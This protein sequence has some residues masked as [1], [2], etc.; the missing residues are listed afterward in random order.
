M[1]R[2][3]EHRKL[4]SDLRE[5]LLHGP[6]WLLVE[7]HYTEARLRAVWAEYG[8]QVMNEYRTE[9][10]CGEPGF[11]P[12]AFW[13]FSAGREE[14]TA[15]CPEADGNDAEFGRAL[16]EYEFEP[17]IWLARNGHLSQREAKEIRYT[18]RAAR[19]RVGTDEERMQ[20]AAISKDRSAVR[21]AEAV[22]TALAGEEAAEDHGVPYSGSRIW[23]G[24]KSFEKRGRL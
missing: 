15:A 5:A 2:L 17:I 8:G 13:K 9:P 10:G 21:L 23:E 11:R 24:N 19:K 18:A 16:D 6:D 7:G 4:T 20:N 1:S 3:K 12:W 14:Y 22:D